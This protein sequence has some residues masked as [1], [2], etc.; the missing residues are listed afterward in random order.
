MR[1]ILGYTCR[2]LKLAG[3]FF[4]PNTIATVIHTLRRT[5]VLFAQNAAMHKSVVKYDAVN[6]DK[7]FS[8]ERI[9]TQG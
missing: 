1:F 9:A 2:S 3:Y 8:D 4:E 6:A 5:L 7:R